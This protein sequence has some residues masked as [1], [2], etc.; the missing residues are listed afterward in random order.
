[1]RISFWFTTPKHIDPSNFIAGGAE[2]Q[3]Y[4]LGNAL[5]KLGHDVHFYCN[6]E[7]NGN[8][9]PYEKFGTDDH[10]WVIIV[11]ASGILYQQFKAKHVI[12]WTG[13]AYDQ[14]NNW[15]LN[16]DRLISKLHKIVFKSNWQLETIHE[17]FVI[18]A[19]ADKSVFMPTGL[20]PEHYT[21][22]KPSVKQGFICTSRIFRGIDRFIHIWPEVYNR[23]GGEL[24]LLVGVSN[25]YSDNPES[26]VPYKPYLDAL[27]KIE[28]VRLMDIHDQKQ[29]IQ[30]MAESK[31]MLYPNFNFMESSCN[32]AF[33]SMAAG[34][35]VITTAKAGLPEAINEGIGQLIP[36]YLP[37]PEYTARMIQHIQYY[38]DNPDPFNNWVTQSRWAFI[39]KH[40]WDKVAQQWL[41]EVLC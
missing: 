3:A 9:H 4:G 36:D 16:D 12:L 1:M 20:N 30:L 35:P 39:K 15:M 17:H 19:L 27:S 26:D 33:E 37:L 38:F 18:T 31:L 29:T 22:Y 7:E 6:T 28:G 34:T 10:E 41:K 11:R 23:F 21:E 25:L 24:K 13:D 40:S 14:P 32:S 5:S 2:L 8:Y